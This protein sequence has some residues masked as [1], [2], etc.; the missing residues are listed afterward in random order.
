MLEEGALEYVKLRP[1]R[2][3]I[4]LSRSS[5]KMSPRYAGIFVIIKRIGEVAYEVDLPRK[6]R[7][8]GFFMYRCLKKLWEELKM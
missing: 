7:S 4:V 5:H 6:Q 1:Y 3:H 8:R 2:Q